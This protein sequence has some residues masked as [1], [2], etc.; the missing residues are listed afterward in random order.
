[1]I[2]TYFLDTG[3]FDPSLACRTFIEAL[4][5]EDRGEV[6]DVDAV[7]QAGV[8]LRGLNDGDIAIAVIIARRSA[9]QDAESFDFAAV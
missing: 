2:R 9:V 4:F 3:Y 8:F 6:F 1:M 5:G 7:A